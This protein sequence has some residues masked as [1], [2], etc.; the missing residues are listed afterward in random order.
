MDL[1]NFLKS[2]RD[3]NSHDRYPSISDREVDGFIHYV[4]KM[5]ASNKNK[6]PICGHHVSFKDNGIG[7]CP[8][9]DSEF[10][11]YF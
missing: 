7:Y 9:C 5:Q 10:Y 4:E 2:V 8:I 3:V 1:L 11:R 6:C